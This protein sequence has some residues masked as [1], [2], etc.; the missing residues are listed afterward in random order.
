VI[1]PADITPQ[2]LA[3]VPN[4][5]LFDRK[6]RRPDWTFIVAFFAFREHCEGAK[7]SAARR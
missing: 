3:E 5:P 4:F 7:V 1:N 2:P 6:P